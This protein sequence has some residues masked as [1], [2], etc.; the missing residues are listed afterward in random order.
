[1]N[2]HE[3]KILDHI[4]RRMHEDTSI[5]APADAIKYVKNLYRTRAVE[6]GSLVK[7]ILAVLKMDLAPDR[8]A[9]GERSA[10]DG[11]ARQMLFEAGDNAVDLRIKAVGKHFEVHGQILGDGFDNG[12]IE[13]ASSLKTITTEIDEMSEFN[14]PE[15]PAG[16]YN[17]T[18]SGHR[19][20]I[21]IEEVT[22][23]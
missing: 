4:V 6:T 11:Q 9:F 8:A 21:V 12:S 10:A 16:D 2:N 1:M 18:I 14:F 20:E 23:R 22:V 19:K 17:I 3:E 13:I 15:V 5:D 7:R